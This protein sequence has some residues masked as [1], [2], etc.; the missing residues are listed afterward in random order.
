[1]AHLVRTTEEVIPDTGDGTATMSAENRPARFV[2]LIVS[3]IETILIIRL[4]LA[5]LGA[6]SNNVFA[7]FIYAIS[8]PFVQPFIGLFSI[9]PSLGVSRLEIETLMALVV[10]ALIGWIIA[11]ALSLGSKRRG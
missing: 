9:A 4:L 8:Y 1:M 10:V 2:Y 5:L 11:N 7:S 3:V 6:N